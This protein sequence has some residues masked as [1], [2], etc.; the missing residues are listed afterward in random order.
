MSSPVTLPPELRRCAGAALGALT[1]AV[2]LAACGGSGGGHA[3]APGSSSLLAQGRQLYVTQ[4]CQGCHTLNGNL[5][6]G[7]SWKGLYGRR[8][9]LASG[10]TVIATAAYLKEHILDPNALTVSGYPGDVMAEAIQGDDL[11][12]KPAYVRALVAF[13]ESVR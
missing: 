3:K 2:A 9:R 1:I 8:V 10:R 7:P 13:I 12:R 4:G 11:G 6:T 5:S